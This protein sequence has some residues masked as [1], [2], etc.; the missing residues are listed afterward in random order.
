[1][2]DRRTGP[3]FITWC[4]SN[5]LSR[6]VRSA[7]RSKGL[8]WSRQAQ[9]TLNSSNAARYI[10]TSFL[11]SRILLSDKVRIKIS[12]QFHVLVY[13]SLLLTTYASYSLPGLCLDYDYPNFFAEQE[14]GFAS[15]AW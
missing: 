11:K 8:H 5:Y 14:M 7:Y 12:P 9:P 2:R 13:L 3:V 4:A 10:I 6:R 15:T 1:M